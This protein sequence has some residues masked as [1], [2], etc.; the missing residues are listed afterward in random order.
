ME[1]LLPLSITL[2]C[3]ITNLFTKSIPIEILGAIEFLVILAVILFFDKIISFSKE[4]YIIYRIYRQNKKIISKFR[5]S[6]PRK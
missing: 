3:F 4:I 2:I 6:K 5:S 1:Y